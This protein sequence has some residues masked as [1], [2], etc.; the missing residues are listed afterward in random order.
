VSIRLLEKLEKLLYRRASSI[1]VVTNVFKEDITAKVGNPKKISVV[2]NGVDGSVFNRIGKKADLV[3]QH[4]LENK[5]VIGYIGTHGLA[6]DLA[7]VINAAEILKE[8]SDVV[9]MFVGSGAERSTIEN[10][11]NELQLSNVRMIGQQ[12]RARMPEFLSLCDISLIPLRD[13]ELFAT[14]IPSKLFE[15]MAMGIPVLM[16]LPE[17]EATGIVKST[18][19]GRAIAPSN[20]A[21]MAEAIVEMASSPAALQRYSESGVSAAKHY[22]RD[23]FADQMLQVLDGVVTPAS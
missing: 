21:I 6:H 13:A 1:V 23:N 2:L 14:V 15:S 16:S 3:Q 11:V 4:E 18:G 20:P 12:A 8:R 5:F 22:S 17:G 7:N 10:K 19:C 9:F